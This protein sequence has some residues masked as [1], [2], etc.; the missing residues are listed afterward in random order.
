MWNLSL[1]HDNGR[2]L[3]QANNWA[4][5]MSEVKLRAL[6][7]L[8]FLPS[9]WFMREQLVKVLQAEGRTIDD[10]CMSA[11]WQFATHG[12]QKVIE[13]GNRVRMMNQGPASTAQM[14]VEEGRGQEWARTEAGGDGED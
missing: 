1:T 6:A 10:T 7:R 5:M 12:A 3:V 9:W 13:K 4:S 2:M 14:E 8:N 11:Q